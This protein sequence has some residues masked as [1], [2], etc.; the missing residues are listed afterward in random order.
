MKT[1]TVRD[2]RNHY[3][4]LLDWIAA[5]EEIVITRRGRAIAR[6]VPEPA[7]SGETADWNKSPAMLRNRSELKQPSKEDVSALLKESS[8]KW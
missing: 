2:L 3:T 6:L 1:A 7:E 5:G 8:G 4:G